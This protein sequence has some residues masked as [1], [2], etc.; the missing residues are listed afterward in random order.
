MSNVIFKIFKF[1]SLIKKNIITFLGYIKKDKT[2]PLIINYFNIY[3]IKLHLLIDEYL[4]KFPL[5]WYTESQI[6]S[7]YG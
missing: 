1:V 3:I 5:R 4:Y 6:R 2:L 7:P